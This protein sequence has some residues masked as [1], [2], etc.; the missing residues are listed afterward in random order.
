MKKLCRCDGSTSELKPLHH[1]SQP[2][3]GAHVPSVLN[4]TP[5]LVL[6]PDLPDES[7]RRAERFLGG[8]GKNYNKSTLDHLMAFI[9]HREFARDYIYSDEELHIIQPHHVLQWMNVKTF[10]IANPGIDAN[11]ISARSNSLTY[12]KKAISFFHPNRF[13]RRGKSLTSK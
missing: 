8:T 13:I 5:G 7:S 6:G 10:G 9:C 3:A 1:A 2:W 11:P 12:W 4:L